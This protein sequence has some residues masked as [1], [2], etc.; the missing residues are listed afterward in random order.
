MELRLKV[1]V[2]EALRVQ[3]R[4]LFT[5]VRVYGRNVIVCVRRGRG[6]S[7]EIGSANHNGDVARLA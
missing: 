7:V 3:L 1:S 4:F 2:V 6:M 5:K